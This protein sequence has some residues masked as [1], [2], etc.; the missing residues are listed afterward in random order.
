LIRT[1]KEYYGKTE[2]FKKANFTYTRTMALSFVVPGAD[3]LASEELRELK[4]L[5]KKFDK[6][7]LADEPLPAKQLEKNFWIV[8]PENENR[9]RGIELATSFKELVATLMRK[10]GDAFIVQ[11]YIERPLLYQGRKFDIRVLAVI[12]NDRNFYLY[13]PCYLRTSS[14]AYTLD[15]Q[16]KY[17][18]LT[19]NCFQMHSDNYQRHEA[20]NQIPYCAFLEYLDQLGTEYADLDKDHIMQR[21]KDI[22]ID[23]HLAAAGNLDLRKR[24]GYKLEIVGFDFLLDEDFRVW[25]LEVNTCPYMGPV[26]T[27]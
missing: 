12:D 17:I 26:L 8:K 1:L 23:C 27:D 2:A 9:G 21:M 7:Q 11:K 5:F 15:S 6:K 14:D 22:M 20:D 10:Q 19:N 4:K 13:K 16:S 24:P 18:H 3:C 25:L